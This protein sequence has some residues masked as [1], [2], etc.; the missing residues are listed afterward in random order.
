MQRGLTAFL[1]CCRKADV[2]PE[3]RA[4][5]SLRAKSP[6]IQSLL[7]PYLTDDD[8]A[9]GGV[10]TEMLHSASPAPGMVL[11]SEMVERGLSV[12]AM[13]LRAGRLAPEVKN[14]FQGLGLIEGGRRVRCDQVA[15]CCGTRI[16]CPNR[17][18]GRA[19]W[20]PTTSML[21]NCYYPRTISSNPIAR[22]GWR[23]R[24]LSMMLC[25]GLFR[26]RSTLARRL[27]LS[28]RCTQTAS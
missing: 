7:V 14:V 11:V 21:C 25:S 9:P 15:T 4:L 3:F 20:E 16:A 19:S 1:L 5:N 17:D 6:Y 22:A 27:A 26:R 18:G 8:Y 10:A 12:R 23:R 2:Y 28:R 13:G 24:T